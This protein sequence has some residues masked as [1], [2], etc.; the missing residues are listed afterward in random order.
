MYGNLHQSGTYSVVDCPTH[1]V[2]LN[3]LLFSSFGIVFVSLSVCISWQIS[4]LQ[5]WKNAAGKSAT[6]PGTNRSPGCAKPSWQLSS[7]ASSPRSFG[8]LSRAST[9]IQR[10]VPSFFV[11][12]FFWSLRWWVAWSVALQNLGFWNCLLT[13]LQSSSRT[14]ILQS[15]IM[16]KW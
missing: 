4:K 15:N 14:V 10:L 11:F 13:N 7:S 5:I 6:Y 2:V 1:W 16:R 9:S 3:R 8:C 12:P